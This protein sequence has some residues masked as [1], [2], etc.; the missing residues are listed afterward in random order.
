[1]DGQ[2]LKTVMSET[3]IVRSLKNIL[4]TLETLI[5]FKRSKISVFLKLFK[6]GS[7]EETSQGHPRFLNKDIF[8]NY[9]K[10]PSENP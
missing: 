1:M 3:A 7:Y 6:K 9:N 2:G 8:L 10:L 4:Q 5:F